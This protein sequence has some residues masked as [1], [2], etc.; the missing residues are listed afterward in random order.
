LSGRA[1]INSPR[2]RSLADWLSLALFPLIT[3]W[4]L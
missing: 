1:R 4:Y 2:N 3:L